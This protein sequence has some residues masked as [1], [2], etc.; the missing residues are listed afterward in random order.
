MTGQEARAMTDEKLSSEVKALRSQLFS[1]RSQT[2]T[3]KVED[4]S[5]FRKI[6]RDIARLLL[7]QTE[8]SRAASGAKPARTE[9]TE[10][11]SGRKPA[12]AKK[13]PAKSKTPAK[14]KN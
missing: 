9:K 14:A 5:Q 11:T 6:R 8:R 3:E 2:V 13:A 12:A 4:N 10:K 7:V 1:L